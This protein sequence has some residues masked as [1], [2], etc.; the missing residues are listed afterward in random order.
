MESD[1]LLERL[2]DRK[3][4]VVLKHFLKFPD[5]QF[6]L[7]EVA[8]STRI[9]LAT[10]FRIVGRL[11]E[12]DLLKVTK[13]KG[14]KLYSWDET[15]SS[16]YIQYILEQKKTVLDSFVEKAAEIAGIQMMVLHGE[17]TKTQASVLVIGEHIDET[18]L[19]GLVVKAKEESG[20][21]INC[22]SLHP[23]Q[24]NQMSAMGLYPKKKVILFER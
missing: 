14:F 20:F 12:L 17:A 23:E 13:I 22:L 18:A 21:T 2:F 9:P 1:K 19:R 3:K 6:Y 5:Q 15:D 10:V 7:R 16:K 24:F 8:R 4:L 11:V